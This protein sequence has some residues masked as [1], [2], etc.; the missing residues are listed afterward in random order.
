[1]SKPRYLDLK[2]FAAYVEARPSRLGCWRDG[3]I[4]AYPTL[5]WLNVQPVVELRKLSGE[6]GPFAAV[7]MSTNAHHNKVGI[8]AGW[9]TQYMTGPASRVPSPEQDREGLWRLA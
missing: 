4:A 7:A 1:M 5:A 2:G 9:V 3:K 6:I 8:G